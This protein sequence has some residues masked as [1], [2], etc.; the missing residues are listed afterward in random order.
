MD[1]SEPKPAERYRV[2]RKL[3]R[4]I[5][6]DDALIGMMDSAAIAQDVVIALSGMEA[7]ETEIDRLRARVVELEAEL[8]SEQEELAEHADCHPAFTAEI[9]RLS[10]KLQAAKDEIARLKCES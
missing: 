1:M 2:G 5:Y 6:C 8:K 9:T 7:L 3:G 4:T 10:E